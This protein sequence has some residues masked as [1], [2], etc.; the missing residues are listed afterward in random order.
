MVSGTM[1]PVQHGR[2]PAKKRGRPMPTKKGYV[3]AM[4]KH[5]LQKTEHDPWTVV[6]ELCYSLGIDSPTGE[7]HANV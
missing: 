1:L 3:W 6:L 7:N 5:R 2:A 4:L